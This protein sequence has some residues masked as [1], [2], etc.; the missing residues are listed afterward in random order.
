MKNLII[1][2][3]GTSLITN[4]ASKDKVAELYKYSN[5][6]KEECP[7]S[8]KE[9]IDS[10]VPLVK[11]KLKVAK[12]NEIRRISA[13]LNG[14]YGFYNN[15]LNNRKNDIHFLISTNTYQG[16]KSAEVVRDYIQSKEIICDIFTPQNLSTKNKEDFSE[17]IKEILKWFDDVINSYK[18]QGYK[19]IFNL[20]GGFKSLQGYLNTLAMFYADK[21]VYIFESEQSELIEIPRLPVRIDLSPFE[22][23][24]EKLLLLNANRICNINEFDELP[25]AVIDQLGGDVILSVWGEVIWKKIKFDLFETLPVLPFIRYNHKFSKDYTELIDKTKK[26]KLIETIAKVS[27]LLERKN[28]ATTELSSGGIKFSQLESMK[29]NGMS[30]YHFRTDL[31]IRINCVI[32]VSGLLLTEFGTHDQTQ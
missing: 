16:L 19:I 5:C 14:I 9:L 23:N 3:V 11:N 20:T 27:V 22:K 32:T 6:S 24:K 2:T 31:G 18:Q 8:I 21:I 15:D 1:S 25:E 17:G 12:I 7:D 10:F 13:E 30:L 28:G 4:P 26:I 29:H